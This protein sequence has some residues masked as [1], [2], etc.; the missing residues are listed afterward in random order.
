MKGLTS[1]SVFPASHGVI[2]FLDVKVITKA[3][4]TFDTDIHRKETDTN[5]YM[6]WNSFAP[7]VWKIGTLKGLVRRA[8]VICSN[9]EFRNKEL[10]FLKNVFRK[11]NGFPS[12][13][14]HTTIHSV[15]LKIEAKS[16]PKKRNS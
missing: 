2:S 10:S 15:K 11:V 1:F 4:R 12:K 16:I 5:I 3:N 7:R 6:N 14:I 9:E 8:F 13:V